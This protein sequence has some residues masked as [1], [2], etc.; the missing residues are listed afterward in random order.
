M[1]KTY[2]KLNAKLLLISWKQNLNS[3]KLNEKTS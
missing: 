1:L 3:I 2:L